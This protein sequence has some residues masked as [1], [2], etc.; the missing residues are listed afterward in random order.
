MNSDI[1]IITTNGLDEFPNSSRD[2]YS[3]KT[4]FSRHLGQLSRGNTTTV[5]AL[6]TASDVNASLAIQLSRARATIC[7]FGGSKSSSQQSIEVNSN[8]GFVSPSSLKQ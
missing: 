1:Y 2:G 6:R 7:P 8:L 5:N 3:S 4:S